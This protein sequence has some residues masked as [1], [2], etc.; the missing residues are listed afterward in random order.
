MARRPVP[1]VLTEGA[2]GAGAVGGAGLAERDFPDNPFARL[3][4]EFGGGLVGQGVSQPTL[5]V[6]EGILNVKSIFEM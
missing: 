2:I 1:F 4:F 5:A 6:V 3:M